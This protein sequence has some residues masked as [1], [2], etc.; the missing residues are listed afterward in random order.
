MKTSSSGT[1]RPIV[2]LSLVGLGFAGGSCQKCAGG[3]EQLCDKPQQIGINRDGGFG[4][5]LA[6]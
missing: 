6:P 1:L 2:W 3:L 5:R 4:C